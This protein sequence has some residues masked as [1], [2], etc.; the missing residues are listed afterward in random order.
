MKHGLFS[1]GFW[2]N[3]S[4]SLPS[5]VF[6]V[7]EPYHK[8]ELNP[9]GPGDQR[10]FYIHLSNKNGPKGFSERIIPILAYGFSGKCVF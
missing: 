3:L 9:H 7:T 6:V 4:N 2:L 10:L 5:F 1:I 8:T